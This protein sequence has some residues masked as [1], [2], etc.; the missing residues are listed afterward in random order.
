M[1][2]LFNGIL[3][4]AILIASNP[5]LGQTKSGISVNVDKNSGEYSILVKPMN[6]KFAG[7]IGK[8]LTNIKSIKGNDLIGNYSEI[9]FNWND[10]N[11]YEGAIKWY[12]NKPIVMFLLTLL[13]DQTKSF[14]AFPTFTGYPAG[15]NKFSFNND[16]FAPPQFKL[17][18]TSTPW[19]FF[20]IKL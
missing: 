13:S 11:E 18:E 3:L 7:R 16:N 9:T 2:I 19:L 20:D 12:N 8:E 10:N 4:F 15:M 14:Y 5:M 1:K 6:W 17:N